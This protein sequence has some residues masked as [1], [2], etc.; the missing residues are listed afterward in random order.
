MACRMGAMLRRHLDMARPAIAG[1][2]LATAIAATAWAGFEE[3]KQAAIEGDYATAFREWQPLAEEGLGDAQFL[4][5]LLYREGRGVPQDFAE[6]VRW[7]GRAA[8]QGHADAQFYLAR[9]LREGRGTEADPAAAARWFR[10]AAEQG[11]A[12]AA[13]TLGIMYRR[14]EG[15]AQDDAEAARWYREAAY[16]GHGEARFTLGAV[17][18]EG[19]GVEP[20][21][22]R[23]Y[24]W[25]ALADES[26]VELGRVLRDRVA[27]KMNEQELA[28]AKELMAQMRA[29]PPDGGAA[30]AA[31]AE[32]PAAASP[33]PPA[34]AGDEAPQATDSARL[35]P[36]AT[37]PPPSALPSEGTAVGAGGYRIRLASYRRAG[38]PEHGWR[39]LAKAHRDLLGALRPITYSVDLGAGKGVFYRL[40]AG[41]FRDRAEAA[42]LC[43]ALAE[44]K[45]ECLVVAP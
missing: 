43:N 18:E 39:A 36:P 11:H 5:G 20:D 25:Y 6:S 12:E 29:G 16:R 41:P 7:F 21:L 22:A 42:A 14:G 26:G 33:E 17:T 3:G 40:E 35:E 45:V 37:V 24:A 27:R 30:S 31:E 2:V 8:K 9:A 23:A 19:R 10:A 1:L 15:V 32:A 13:F 38:G 4:L 34:P 44:R 28:M